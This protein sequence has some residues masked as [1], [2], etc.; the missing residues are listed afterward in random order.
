MRLGDLLQNRACVLVV[1]H[2]LAHVILPGLRNE[3]LVYLPAF[4]CD[5]VERLRRFRSGI[6]TLCQI[7]GRRQE[8][9]PAA[10]IARMM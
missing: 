6:M 1:P 4:A 10:Q 3:E 8:S 5:Y 2:P 7:A 9:F